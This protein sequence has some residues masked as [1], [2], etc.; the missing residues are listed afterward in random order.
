MTNLVVILREPDEAKRRRVTRK[1]YALFCAKY[2]DPSTRLPSLSSVSL[3]QDDNA[4]GLSAPR[5]QQRAGALAATSA[6]PR[7]RPAGEATTPPALPR[8]WECA[9]P[10]AVSE[11]LCPGS[12][13]SPCRRQ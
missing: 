7:P 10:E 3:A 13:L 2:I 12:A 11:G 1:I 6:K 5:N 8:R 4:L 9:I